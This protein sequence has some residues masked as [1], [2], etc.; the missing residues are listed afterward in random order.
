MGDSRIG[1]TSIL[2]KRHQEA[3]HADGNDGRRLDDRVEGIFWGAITARATGSGGVGY[4]SG[5]E[6][7]RGAEPDSLH[8]VIIYA[9]SGGFLA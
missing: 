4:Y 1:K 8:I 5:I 9:A 6:M 2:S 3:G 7:M